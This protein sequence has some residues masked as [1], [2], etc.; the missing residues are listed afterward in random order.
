MNTQ[1]T[2]GPYELLDDAPRSDGWRVCVPPYPGS[3]RRITVGFFE[4]KAD[5]RLFAAAPELLEGAREGLRAIEQHLSE[6]LTSHCHLDN[7]LQPIRDTLEECCQAEAEAMEA[8]ITK[9][10]AA[11]AKAEGRS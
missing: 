8:R 10:R 2:S 11:I 5:A 7:T 1:H 3:L 9:I 4:K 6:I